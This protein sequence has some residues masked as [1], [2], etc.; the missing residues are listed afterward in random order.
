M[1]SPPQ[2]DIQRIGTVEGAQKLLEILNFDPDQ[3]ILNK[4][5]LRASIMV[6]D[7]YTEA[8]TRTALCISTKGF[9]L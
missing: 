7:I 3:A 6:V 1:S 2:A 4:C 9:V 5:N 8:G